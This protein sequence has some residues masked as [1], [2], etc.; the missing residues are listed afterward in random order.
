MNGLAEHPDKTRMAPLAKNVRLL[1]A[2]Q[3]VG[4]K[5][6]SF[7]RALVRSNIRQLLAVVL[8]AIALAVPPAAAQQAQGL[9]PGMQGLL[10]PFTFGTQNPLDAARQGTRTDGPAAAR[11]PTTADGTRPTIA[12]TDDQRIVAS[13]FCD[14]TLRSEERELLLRIPNFSPLERDYC[15]RAAQLL[16]AYGYETFDG[17]RSSDALAN[18]SVPD[19]YRLGVGDEIVITLR[20]QLSTTSRAIVDR[21][22]RIIIDALGPIPAAGRLFG[23]FRRELAARVQAAFIGTEAFVSLSNLRL[24]VVNVIGEVAI[25]GQHQLTALST[26][27]DALAL[28]GGVKKTGSLRRIMVQ[29]LDTTFWIDVYDLLTGLGPSRDLTLYEGDRIVVP[30]LGATVAVGGK[31]RR[32]AI[33]ELPEGETRTTV[34]Q[35]IELAGGPL[36]PQGNRVFVRS[37]DASG[38]EVTAPNADRSLQIG[39]GDLVL[40]EYGDDT[41]VNIVRIEGSVRAPGARVRS[42][43]PTVRTLLGT[44]SLGADAYLPLSVLETMDPASGAS[45]YFALS[46]YRI[47]NGEQDFSL[48]DNDRLIVLSRSDVRFLST[49]RVQALIRPTLVERGL[50]TAPVER[51]LRTAPVERGL[52]TG[53]RLGI[54]EVAADQP[55]LPLPA[56]RP[57]QAAPAPATPQVDRDP[58][59]LDRLTV[60][61]PTLCAGIDVLKGIVDRTRSQR[62]ASAVLAIDVVPAEEDLAKI[63]CPVVF[64]NFPDLLP[65]VLEHVAALNGEIRIPG[66]YPVAPATPIAVVVAAAGGVTLDADLSRVEFTRF[67]S[68]QRTGTTRTNRQLADIST[69]QGAGVTISPSDIVRFNAVYSEL[70]AGPVL[71]A[72]EFIRPGYFDIR[73][74]ERLSEV[75]AR[76]GGLTDQAYPFGAVFTRERVRQAEQESFQR[77]ARDLNSAVVFA[78]SRGEL[79]PEALSV[80]QS[81]SRQITSTEAVG[82]IVI[83][84]DPT[85]LQVRPE[86]DI[87]LEPGDTIFMPKRPNSVLVIGDVLNPGS[88]QFVA[89]TRVENYIRQA[90]GYQRSADE[91]RVFLVYPNGVAQQIEAGTWTFAPPTQVPPGSTIVVPKDPAPLGGLFLVREFT[92]LISQIAVTAASLAVISR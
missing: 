90:G 80:L 78:V 70:A 12:L 88:L 32:P 65:F 61:D 27:L 40:V 21:E 17:A 53:Q 39:E 3:G 85:V 34:G 38:R 81:L 4:G 73:R 29:R 41:Q 19:T 10:V 43:A 16:P 83:E 54:D 50:R 59:R 31:V 55:Q 2:G 6:M 52:R 77:S 62:F 14:G 42:T 64:N 72:G 84:A 76:A 30:A 7:A 89:G 15:L 33:F 48:R 35:V 13:R 11:A 60:P 25:P 26:V 9:S 46:L 24:I 67:E 23:D 91:S 66:A 63:P 82:R 58:L 5:Y 28:A 51:G 37:I 75:I 22:G 56:P 86:F 8:A 74:G 49:E 69:T 87:V 1:V 36:R 18:G 20:G 45:R 79:R 57:V 71:L 47:L 68:E 44:D 92:S